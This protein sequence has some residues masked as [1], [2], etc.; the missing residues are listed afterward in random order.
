MSNYELNPNVLNNFKIFSYG[1][2]NYW[3]GFSNNH[4]K[5]L[6]IGQIIKKICNYENFL[7]NNIHIQLSHKTIKISINNIYFFINYNAIN[8]I[9]NVFI[10]IEEIFIQKRLIKIS[11][12]L[13]NYIKV[14]NL[15]ICLYNKYVPIN[16]IIEITETV[17]KA[18]RSEFYFKVAIQTV[19]SVFIGLISSNVLSTIIYLCIRR[20]PKRIKF[21]TFLKRLIDWHFELII[22]KDSKIEGVRAEIKGRFNPKARAKKHI[23]S[24]GKI[25]KKEKESLVDFKHIVAITKFGSLSIKVWVCPLTKI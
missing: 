3:K 11:F 19:Y 5:L 9:N 6:L 24:V 22:S 21:L 10:D 2:N 12:L 18:E 14:N 17:F 15:Q 1:Y 8:R 25:R 16:Y 13:I 4:Y 20:N 23:L 7:T